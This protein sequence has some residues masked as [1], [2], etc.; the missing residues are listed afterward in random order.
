L[1]R[2]KAGALALAQEETVAALNRHSEGARHS[3][4]T[5]IETRDMLQ[6]SLQEHRDKLNRPENGHQL[7]MQSSLLSS[8]GETQWVE[9]RLV[10]S[11]RFS[12][13]DDR[14]FE[15][16]EAHQRTF[17][18]IF[19]PSH[20]TGGNW[21]NF[22]EWLERG[23][24]LYWINGKAGSG[25]STLMRYIFDTQQTR[26]HLQTWSKEIQLEIAAFFFWNTGSPDQRSQV[27]L[28]RSL[29]YQAL[30]KRPDLVRHIFPRQWAEASSALSCDTPLEMAW[31]LRVLKAAF[32]RWIDFAPAAS[33]FCFFIDGL[34][35]YEGDKE[36][37]AEFFKSIS[38]SL[39]P[40]IKICVS[41][42]PLVEFDEA[43]DGLPS[44][45][46]Q[47][48]T[49]PDITAYA[50]SELAGN[51]R[52]HFLPEK[53]RAPLVFEIV[54]KAAG[55]FLWVTLVVR[56]LLSGLRN[57]DGIYD[58]RRRLQELPSGLSALYSH[59]LNNVEPLYQ[60]QASQTFR[61]YEA[62]AH[63]EDVTNLHFQLA[64]SATPE[65]ISSTSWSPMVE[66]EIMRR[67]ES[68]D[69]HLKTRCG[70]LLEIHD[71]NTGP[72]SKVNYLHRTVKEFLDTPEVRGLILS[73]GG[74]D[75]DPHRST[76]MSSILIMKKS[77]EFF[78]NRS[79][80][81][82]IHVLR[83]GANIWTCMKP[84]FIYARAAEIRGDKS[85]IPVLDNLERIAIQ[86]WK[87]EY[88]DSGKDWGEAELFDTWRIFREALSHGLVSYVEKKLN[89]NGSLI[90]GWQGIP[91]LFHALDP[92][93]CQPFPHIE[94]ISFLLRRG[95]DPNRLWNG[96]SPWQELLGNLHRTYGR[97]FL[98]FN[99]EGRKWTEIF[100][101]LLRSGAN[102]LQICHGDSYGSAH[103]I[104]T[105]VL[106]VFQ[107]LSIEEFLE[108]E[109]LME[110]KIQDHQETQLATHLPPPLDQ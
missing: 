88:A 50:E 110:E 72:L 89:E 107:G 28:F 94:I 23:T 69:I 49:F 6:E 96:K 66:G 108:L 44:L 105:V 76:M 93:K 51:R 75:F 10:Q 31:S 12:S 43:F 81:N 71:T 29:L 30:Y 52:M 70:G 22:V 95:G 19:S 80:C 42:R 32:K 53:E 74:Q 47:D 82:S 3:I 21:S 24:G 46:L 103:S 106:A 56:L 39:M 14:H 77:L 26:R 84:A 20:Q 57:R 73:T 2:Y 48:L 87:Q 8:L 90:S 61:I 13:M 86:R 60:E 102:P 100:K 55:V 85:Y 1:L 45:R 92:S 99:E 33:K 40:H 54:N 25:K 101:L 27:G 38:S 7:K 62:M 36:E 63:V 78:R 67:C 5:L 83:I 35:E 79:G 59:M 11:L 68:L 34:D 4:Q 15:I 9:I 64:I 91:L 104:R 109:S 65:S 97:G 41:G 98:S 18:W 16:P 17:R 58:L 37:M